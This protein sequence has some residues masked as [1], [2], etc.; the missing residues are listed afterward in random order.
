MHVSGQM[1]R[2]FFTRGRAK[3][4]TAADCSDFACES[5]HDLVHLGAPAVHYNMGKIG[6][7]WLQDVL[8]AGWSG[9]PDEWCDPLF[10]EGDLLLG[11]TRSALVVGVIRGFYDWKYDVLHDGGVDQVDQGALQSWVTV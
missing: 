10:Y 6:R 5:R 8:D 4:D 2:T 11:G 3:P 7:E 9:E 1:Y